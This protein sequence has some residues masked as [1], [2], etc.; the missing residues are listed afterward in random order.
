M[1]WT[2]D[3]IIV[4]IIGLTVFFAAKNGLIKTAISAVACILA[5]V[6]TASFAEPLAE[7]MMSTPI[8]DEIEKATETRITDFL[9]EGSYEVDELI[10]GKSEEFNTFIRM[11]GINE[12]DI[13]KWYAE[14]VVDSETATSQLA[15][16]IAEPI[17]NVTAMI[18]AITVLFVG[19]QVILSILAFL[20]DKIARLPVLRT[21][22]KL[23]GIIVG[24]VLAL[25]RVCL[26]CFIMGILI[27]N[28]DFLASDFITNLKPENTLL[29]RLFNQI[30]I[31][32]FFIK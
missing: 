12:S 19:T 6:I 14:N 1:S 21:F 28:R 8:A 22:N 2:L 4:L 7:Y 18:L 31:F 15:K 30:D 13:Q 27:E 29:F 17:I 20:L 25:I 32:S 16:H 11:A 9:L 26:F 5:I 23:G 24:V 10:E 3:I